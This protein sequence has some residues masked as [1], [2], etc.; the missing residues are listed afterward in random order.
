MPVCRCGCARAG[1]KRCSFDCEIPRSAI[2]FVTFLVILV[3]LV[4][5]GLTLNPLIHWLGIDESTPDDEAKEEA[6]ARKRIEKAG[7]ARLDQIISH[8]PSLAPAAR[9]LRSHHVQRHPREDKARAAYAR[10]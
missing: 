4:A 9:H 5:Q 10:T 3:S 8:N 2:I 7:V 1:S 6:L